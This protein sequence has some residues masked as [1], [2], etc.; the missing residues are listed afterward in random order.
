MI[1]SISGLEIIVDREKKAKL[2][3]A[4]L[5]NFID[6]K[7]TLITILEYVQ[8]MVQCDAVSIRLKEDNDYPYYVYKGFSESFIRHESSICKSY[9]GS[10]E[11]SGE[12]R[13]NELECMCGLILSGRA[14]PEFECF[15]EKGSFWTNNW[16]ETYEEILSKKIDVKARNYCFTSGYN[17]VAL[18]PIIANKMRIGLI[19]LNDTK[20]DIFSTD[21]IE[22]LEM[23][24]DQVGLAVSNSLI[25][26]QLR[27]EKDQLSAIVKELER[28]QNQL[29]ESEKMA[30]LGRLVAG[31][32]HEINTPLGIGITATT[33]FIQENEKLE[34][35]FHTGS[36]KKSTLEKNICTNKETGELILRNLQR[37]AKLIQ[38][39][40]NTSV[41]QINE[42][43]REFDIIDYIQQ[44]ISNLKPN[45]K[46]KNI[47]FRIS[48][49]RAINITSYPGVFNQILTNLIINSYL[50]GFEEMDD[51][52]IKLKIKLDC[53][54][55]S[56]IY[57]DNGCGIS[58]K[59][60]K[61]I[62]EPFF[63][64]NHKEGTGLGLHIVYNL[65]SQSLKGS[66]NCSSPKKGGTVFKI[67]V[68]VI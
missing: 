10:D 33:A 29:V 43:K 7:N 18:I 3:C 67:E 39:F 1:E 38:N 49:K 47:N 17:S 31:V 11:I 48:P 62:F 52:E 13:D 50:H 56:I 23:I 65:V 60:I 26:E 55:L 6:L 20:T 66:I 24:G 22:F 61:K 36:L 58:E 64:T 30:S 53:G 28:T 16:S 21:L 41:D 51:G 2:I 54:I 34:K 12:I 9:E 44:I 14:N 68:P 15:T 5:N 59:N 63:T 19:Q 37:T 57:S 40:K 27:K 46:S 32:A 35:E 8:G 4:E 25:Y 42:Q 45:I